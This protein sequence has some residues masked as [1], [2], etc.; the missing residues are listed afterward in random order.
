MLRNRAGKEIVLSIVD[1][2]GILHAVPRISCRY[3]D[4]FSEW[5]MRTNLFSNEKRYNLQV[6]GAEWINSKKFVNPCNRSSTAAT[7][8]RY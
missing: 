5:E 3:F 7:V 2:I 6:I 1:G 8:F 4:T